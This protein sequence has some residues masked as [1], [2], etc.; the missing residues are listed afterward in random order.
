MDSQAVCGCRSFSWLC[1]FLCVCTHVCICVLVCYVYV[2]VCLESI[3][4]VAGICVVSS[5][6]GC[7]ERY[8]HEHLTDYLLVNAYTFL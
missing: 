8:C 7:Y 2:R 4:P 6:R 1:I 3:H 5:V